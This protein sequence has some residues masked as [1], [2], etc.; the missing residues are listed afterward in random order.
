MKV[1][2]VIPERCT[3][4]RIC[5]QWCSWGHEGQVGGQ[6]RIHTIREHADYVNTPKVCRQCLDVPCIANCR[7]EALSKD[8]VS[9]AI[10]VNSE[11]CTGCQICRRHCPHGAITYN[12]SNK[13]VRI[14][15]LCGGAPKCVVHCPEGALEFNSRDLCESKR[16]PS[17]GLW[18]RKGE[19]SHE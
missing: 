15:D 4:C 17:R 18:A 6:S 8:P 2:D 10:I 11:L 16:Q 3:G 14:C 13:K 19:E 9:G 1:L 7:F 12:K 5:E